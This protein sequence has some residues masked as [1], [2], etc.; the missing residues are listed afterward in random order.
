MI[1][2]F[3]GFCNLN[4]EPDTCNAYDGLVVPIPTFPIFGTKI[5]FEKMK[6]TAGVL[7]SLFGITLYLLLR[8]QLRNVWNVFG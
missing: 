6:Q 4:S 1:A 8:H 3:P 7:T 5:T 2:S